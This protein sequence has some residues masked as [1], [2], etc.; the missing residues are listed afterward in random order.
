MPE[1]ELRRNGS[2]YMDVRPE[3]QG[4]FNLEIKRRLN[5]SVWSAGCHSW[6]VNEAGRNTNNW[7]DLTLSYRRRTRELDLS[8]YRLRAAT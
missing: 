7:P 3:A 6:Y 2:A 8:A 1:A 4:A 5:D